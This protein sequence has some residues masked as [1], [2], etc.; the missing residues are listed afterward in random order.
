VSLTADL[1]FEAAIEFGNDDTQDAI[2]HHDH[3]CGDCS[4]PGWCYWCGDDI[5][6][7]F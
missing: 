1:D 4:G 6:A 3:D 7:E 2:L 5:D